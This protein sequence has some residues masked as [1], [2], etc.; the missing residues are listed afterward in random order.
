M[1]NR[2]TAFAALLG[3]LLAAPALAFN[4]RAPIDVT[5]T[6]AKVILAGVAGK[7]TRVHGFDLALTAS[8]TVQWKCGTTNV[9]GVMSLTTYFKPPSEEPYF[10]CAAGEDLSITVGTAVQ[11]GGI[12]YYRQD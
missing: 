12:L 6:G 3:I 4:S 9:T 8:S 5:G 7:T 2:R 11:I 1:I 10:A